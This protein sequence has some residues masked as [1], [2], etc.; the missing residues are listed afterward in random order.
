MASFRISLADASSSTVANGPYINLGVGNVDAGTVVSGMLKYG[1][2]VGS[3]RFTY[4]DSESLDTYAVATVSVNG[5]VYNLAF[6]TAFD[7]AAFSV[8]RIVIDQPSI[9]LLSSL[10]SSLPLVGTTNALVVGR[11][12]PS[13]TSFNATT[14]VPTYYTSTSDPSIG[15]V[16]YNH[17]TALTATYDLFLANGKFR[18]WGTDTYYRDYTLYGNP[19]YST[20]AHTSGDYRF[21]TF[22]W[23]IDTTNGFNFNNIAFTINTAKAGSLT[24]DPINFVAYVGG[25]PLIMYYRFEQQS[26]RV[27][28]GTSN[29]NS[30]WV[31]LNQVTTPVSSGNYNI[32]TSTDPTNP[33]VKGGF[34]GR[35]STTTNGD[36]SV[37]YGFTPR[38][39]RAGSITATTYLYCRI[40]LPMNVDFEFAS[41]SANLYST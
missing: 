35:V 39:T 16:V 36:G 27:P 3:A 38:I 37:T 29:F 28:N 14:R 21:I 13:G 10:P 33:V 32:L 2:V 17:T 25:T 12:V 11:L 30:D 31:N 20:I 41:I 23:A 19:N 1:G 7:S 5:Y 8:Q 15:D 4:S 22:A 18:T 40:V 6:P 9:T 26:D 24:F 34:Q